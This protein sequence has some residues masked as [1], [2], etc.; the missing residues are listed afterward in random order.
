M[1]GEFYEIRRITAEVLKINEE[2]L[3]ERTRFMEDLGADSLELFEILTRIEESHRIAFQRDAISKVK[4]LGD[5]VELLNGAVHR[6]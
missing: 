4:T 5:A 3:R 1:T 2:E 6:S